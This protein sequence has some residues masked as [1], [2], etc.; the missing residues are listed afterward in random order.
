MATELKVTNR[1]EVGTGCS[2]RL[3]RN[4]QVPAVLYGLDKTPKQ[5]SVTTKEL[6]AVLKTDSQLIQLAPE[7]SKKINVLIKDVQYN[8]LKGE[9]VHVDF[10]EINMKEE[11]TAS[12]TITPTGSAKGV[13][14][15]GLFNQLVYEIEVSCLPTDLPE[16]IAVDVTEMDIDDTFYIK[17]VILPENVIAV[18]DLETVIFNLAQPKVKEEAT[19]EDASAEGEKVEEESSEA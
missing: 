16:T 5:F 14:Q 8:H 7:K 11:I 12:V 9:T 15:G 6:E 10:Q 2:R 4:G 17:D 19:E 18:S 3:R 13:S 1:S